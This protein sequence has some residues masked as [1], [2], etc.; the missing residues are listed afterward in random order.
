[1][2]MY[3]ILLIGNRGSIK[4]FFHFIKLYISPHLRVV[5]NQLSVHALE[6]DLCSFDCCVVDMDV[7]ELKYMGD[8]FDVVAEAVD[9]G[10]EGDVAGFE[11][12][13][14]GADV[15]EAALPPG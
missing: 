3:L 5:R 12:S 7:V 1:M 8:V 14:E 6:R 4:K 13:E 11:F 15:V 9:S 2:E 10:G